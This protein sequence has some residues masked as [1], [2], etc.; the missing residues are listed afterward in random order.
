MRVSLVM[1]FIVYLVSPFLVV[2]WVI[3]LVA[4]QT[5]V[6]IG[7]KLSHELGIELLFEFQ[8]MLY[9]WRRC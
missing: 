7:E 5:R 3:E 1:R 9:R 4:I 8:R 6:V 2:G